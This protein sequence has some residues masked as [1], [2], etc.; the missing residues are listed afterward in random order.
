ME[1][2][3]SCAAEH[4]KSA[5]GNGLNDGMKN[6]LVTVYIYIMGGVDPRGRLGRV[7]TYI[8]TND[9]ASFNRHLTN[10]EVS[11]MYEIAKGEMSVEDS[12]SEIGNNLTRMF[13]NPRSEEELWRRRLI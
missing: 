1:E 4:V 7:A 12:F 8:K 13:H 6:M 2:L 5:C 11:D 3:V 9:Y 10:S